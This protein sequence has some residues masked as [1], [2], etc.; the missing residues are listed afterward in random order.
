MLAGKPAP[1]A[2]TRVSGC[3]VKGLDAAANASQAQAEADKK[4]DVP[5]TMAGA[6]D[7]KKLRQNGTGKLLL[8]DFWATWCAPCA[9]EFPDLEATY[10]MYRSRNLEFVSVSVDDPEER[11][12]S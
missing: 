6:E 7:L 11:A 3:R 10:R 1:V 12:R 9:R 2:R 5:L 8:V 4:G